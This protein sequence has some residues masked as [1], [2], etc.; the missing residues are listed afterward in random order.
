[1]R[2]MPSG[3]EQGL[4]P[5]RVQSKR[6]WTPYAREPLLCYLYLHRIS[7]LRRRVRAEEKT[8]AD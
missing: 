8:E 3:M 2:S 5:V 6:M 7:E 1:M 4:H